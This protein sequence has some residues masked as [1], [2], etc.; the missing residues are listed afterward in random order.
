MPEHHPGT[1]VFS[2]SCAR[3]PVSSCL[4]GILLLEPLFAL[5]VAAAKKGSLE[6]PPESPPPF[7]AY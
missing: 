1:C 6:S 3:R 7:S 5:A 4:L 2:P